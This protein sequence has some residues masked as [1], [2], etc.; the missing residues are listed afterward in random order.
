MG[1]VSLSFSKVY[2]VFTQWLDDSPFLVHFRSLSLQP[3]TLLV[4]PLS[5]SVGRFLLFSCVI[6]FVLKW[7]LWRLGRMTGR[8]L[9]SKRENK[10]NRWGRERYENERIVGEW[11]FAAWFVCVCVGYNHCNFFSVQSLW[12]RVA[13]GI[14]VLVSSNQEHFEFTPTAAVG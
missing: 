10:N 2:N 11:K 13:H 12:G 9:C 14:R 8:L 4:Y 1:L 3:S 7:G 6:H 5:S